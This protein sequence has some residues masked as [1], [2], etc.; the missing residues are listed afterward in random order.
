MSL[1]K[2][3]EVIPLANLEAKPED[4]D[5]TAETVVIRIFDE[6]GISGIGECDA[7]AYVVKSF[8]EMP[9]QHIW[10][11]NISEILIGSDPIEITA[12]WER[13]YEGTCFPGRRGLGIHALSAI[14]IALHDLVGKQLGIPV[15]KLLGG[16]K[17]ESIHPYCTIFPGMPQGRSIGELMKIIETQFNKALSIGFDAV[18][19]EVMFGDLVDDNELIEQI[20]LGRKMLGDKT[21]LAIDFGYRWKSWADA[22]WVLDRIE[23]CNIYFAEATLQHDDLAG[24]ARLAKNSS[25]RIGGAEHSATRFEAREWLEIGKIHVIQ[26]AIDRAGGLTEMM[27]IAELAEYYGVE[28]IPH[29]W[30]TGITSA[31]GCHFQAASPTTP[32]FEFISPDVFVSPLRRNLVGPEPKINNGRISLP[33]LP[34]LGIELNEDALEHYRTDK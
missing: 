3:I 21:I 20:K 15:Y 2:K 32:L 9:T 34:G 1:I 8:L 17:K 28:V 33:K 25:I 12:L 18:K 10:S 7:P 31:C 4:C 19:M 22:K 30:K 13:I 6:N 24:H 29:G 14:D 5:G 26:S 23:D 16:A 27:R 11:K